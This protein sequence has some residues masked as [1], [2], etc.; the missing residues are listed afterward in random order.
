MRK[1]TLRM[2][3]APWLFATL[4]CAAASAVSADSKDFSDGLTGVGSAPTTAI[5]RDK[6]ADPAWQAQ[7]KAVEAAALAA[8]DR[9]A[10][11]PSS[12]VAPGQLGPGDK[13]RLAVFGEEDLSG[14]FELDNTGS[15]ALPLVGEVPAKGLTAR[16]LERK[17]TDILSK[18]YLVNPRVNIEVMNFRPFFILGE[19]NKPSSYPYVNDLTVINAVA[20]AGGYTP[21]AK[22]GQVKIRRANDPSRTEAIVP[23]DTKVFPGD[24]IRVEERFF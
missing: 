16:E 20:M 21:R 15:L 23:E 1:L 19:V 12:V 18:G 2:G 8:I 17:L 14:E 3:I 7:Q 22:T 6:A 13:V 24:V 10:A 9:V 4:F 11:D 5:T